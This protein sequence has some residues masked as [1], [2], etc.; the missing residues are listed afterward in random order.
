MIKIK[1]I[2]CGK[3][4]KKYPSEYKKFCSRSCAIT[5]RN[6]HNHPLKNPESRKKLSES[7][8]GS[9]PWNKG[10][11]KEDPRV[12]KNIKHLYGN[13]FGK[14]NKGRKSPWTIKRNLEDNPMWDDDVAK[15]AGRSRYKEENYNWRGGYIRGSNDTKKYKELT[16]QVLL[17]DNNKCTQCGTKEGIFPHHIIPRRLDGKDK[18]SNLLTVCRFC[19]PKLDAIA[20]KKYKEGIK[21]NG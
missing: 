8:K 4:T 1:C 7:K 20:W 21:N 15:S 2:Q 14:A 9:I 5:Y 11:T 13:N 3:S 16:K 6:L 12:A 19:H 17:R 18:L 10:L